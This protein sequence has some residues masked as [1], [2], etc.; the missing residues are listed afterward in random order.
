[1]VGVIFNVVYANISGFFMG[2]IGSN[3]VILHEGKAFLCVLLPVG[4]YFVADDYIK[5]DVLNNSICGLL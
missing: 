4:L 5:I 3:K 1:M 2:W